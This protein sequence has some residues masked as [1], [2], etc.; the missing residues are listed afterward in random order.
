LPT[1]AVGALLAQ[2]PPPLGFGTVSLD[3]GPGLGFLA[4][5]AGIGDA[6]DITHL[7]GWRAW[8]R[9]KSGD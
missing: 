9:S 6:P 3:D 4:E 2:V 8:L 1:T 5:S 7:G